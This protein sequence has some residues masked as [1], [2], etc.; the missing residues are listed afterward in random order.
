MAKKKAQQTSKVFGV[1]IVET[2][3]KQ[4]KLFYNSDKRKIS[5]DVNDITVSFDATDAL[6]LVEEAKSSHPGFNWIVMQGV[7]S[8]NQ[9]DDKVT[10]KF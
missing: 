5:E 8:T 10:I 7:L 2:E 6:R 9:E 1:V 4:P 3:T